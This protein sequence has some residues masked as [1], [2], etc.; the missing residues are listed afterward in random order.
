MTHVPYPAW[1][2]AFQEAQLEADESDLLTRVKHAETA[3]YI[4]LQAIASS[5]DH[6]EER[7]AI[8]DAMSV[9]RNLQTKRLKFPEMDR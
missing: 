3:I 8:S 5:S 9:L 7:Q 1:Q 6:H 2:N 4:R